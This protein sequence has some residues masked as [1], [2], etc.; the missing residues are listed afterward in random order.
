MYFDVFNINLC[1]FDVFVYNIDLY[2]LYTNKIKYLI[3]YLMDYL[4]AFVLF[5][6]AGR[7]LRPLPA[8]MLAGETQ[9][10]QHLAGLTAVT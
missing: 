2:V 4:K 6:S 5:V 1:I 3:K 7:S 9:R 8:S 10:T